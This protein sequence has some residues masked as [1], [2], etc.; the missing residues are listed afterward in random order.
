MRDLV[1]RVVIVCFRVIFRALGLRISIE[2]AERIPASGAAVIAANHI[3]FLDFTFIGLAARPQRRLIRF[4]AKRATF[5]NPVSGPLMRAMHHIKVDRSNGA[6]AYRRAIRAVQAGEL[7]GVFPE[8]TISRS[9]TLRP[10]KPGA[11]ALAV[12]EGVPLIPVIAWGGHRLFTVG[13]HRTL[14]RGTAVT[15]LVGEPILPGTDAAE[16]GALLRR[17]MT[18]LL[19]RAQ[20]DYPQRPGPAEDPWWLPRHLGGSAPDAEQAARLDDAAALRSDRAGVG[21]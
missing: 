6:P 15:I 16:V 9:W 3:G 20:R 7:V 4:M 14:R 17:R 10:F 19:D 1:Y 12:R 8:A 2:G 11:A 18:E 5:D 13:G 21:H